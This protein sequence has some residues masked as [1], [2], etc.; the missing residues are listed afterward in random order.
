MH[1]YARNNTAKFYPDLI[2]NNGAVGFFFQ[3]GRPNKEEQEQ[4]DEKWYEISS[5]S[6]VH[7]T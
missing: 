3:R 7:Q 5:W 1:I 6:K 4:Q 2:W